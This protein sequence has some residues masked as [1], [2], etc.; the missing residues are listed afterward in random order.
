MY[1]KLLISLFALLF[2]S[3]EVVAEP[4]IGRLPSGQAYRT[5]AAGNQIVDYIAELEVKN[6]AL[7]RRIRGLVAEVEDLRAHGTSPTSS[8]KEKNLVG[9]SPS[10]KS[11]KGTFAPVA[12]VPSG[13]ASSGA[14]GGSASAPE[15]CSPQVIPSNSCG[16]R[17]CE[18]FISEVRARGDRTIQKQS[19][20]LKAAREKAKVCD[21]QFE[22]FKVAMEAH[23]AEEADILKELNQVKLKTSAREDLL[24]QRQ[25]ELALKDKNTASLNR[26]I[27]TLESEVIRLKGSESALRNTNEELKGKLAKANATSSAGTVTPVATTSTSVTQPPVKKARATTSAS[28][29]RASLSSRALSQSGGVSDAQRTRVKSLYSSVIKM[30]NQRDKLF[31]AYN[32]STLS[33]KKQSVRS[34]N[35]K[36]PEQLLGLVK[37]TNSS[38][39]LYM[40]EKEG[41]RLEKI[42]KSDI[43]LIKRMKK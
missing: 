14:Q 12:V 11:K 30:R 13:G 23:E 1:R 28:V 27:K 8:L 16:E 24:E 10:Y 31:A 29:T 7:E 2:F 34:K 39:D 33:I 6:E 36:M 42:V 43:A 17:E 35:G 41:K 38:R 15:A 37:S 22:A 4:Q 18:I 25:A 32:S 26:K 21:Q 3:F 19:S 9:T 20:E 5:D 40:L